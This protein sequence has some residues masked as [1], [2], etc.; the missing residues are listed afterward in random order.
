M[1]PIKEAFSKIKEEIVYLK[2]EIIS[3]KRE[4]DVLHTQIKLNT[5]S[6]FPTDNQINSPSVVY[7]PTHEQTLPQEIG[8]L[9]QCFND[10]STG[11]RGVPTDNRTN[12]QTDIYSRI[13]NNQTNIYNYKGM[14][15]IHETVESLDNIKKEL[16]ILIKRLTPQEM[17]VLTSIY[18]LESREISSI[19]YRV[20]ASH[21]RLSE[22][23]IR[24]Y[25]N[26]I[27]AKGIPLI[28]TKINNKIISLSISKDLSRI[29]SLS[30]L[31]KL[32]DM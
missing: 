4:V 20:I 13:P 30:I 24:E 31:T 6:S 11:N 8:G 3:L 12:N 21:L 15:D 23:S 17:A 19:T 25:V 32:R 14:S 16:R 5:E 18:E 10:I 22:S 28:K 9:K 26:K 27:I 1:D 2:E 7:E 29:A